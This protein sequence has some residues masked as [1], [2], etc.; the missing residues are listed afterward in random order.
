MAAHAALR[1][2]VYAS[3]SR[4]DTFL[5]MPATEDIETL[6]AE[7]L[8]AFGPRRFVMAIDVWPQRQLA[9]FDGT[10]LLQALHERGYYLQ[11]P[12]PT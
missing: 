7:L 10:T 3:R 9:R 8:R 11:F 4:T 5:Y 12:P 6:D 1:V 2:C